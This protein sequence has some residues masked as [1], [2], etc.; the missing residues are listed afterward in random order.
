MSLPK[1]GAT[2]WNE[3]LDDERMENFDF[4]LEIGGHPTP[5]IRNEYFLHVDLKAGTSSKYINRRRQL[6]NILVNLASVLV[7]GVVAQWLGWRLRIPAILRQSPKRG[8][9]LRRNS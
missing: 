1:I 3:P 9:H 4:R 7:L 8:S 5:F 2:E 6:E